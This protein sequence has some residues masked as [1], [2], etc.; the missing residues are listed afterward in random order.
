[1]SCEPE[2]GAL[3]HL[4]Q[5]FAAHIRDPLHY[6]APAGI[7]DRRMNIYRGLLYRNIEGFIASGFPVLRAILPESRW[8]AM[9]RGFMADYRCQTPYFLEIAQE[10][11]NYLQ[12]SQ[13][14][15]PDPPF[16]I[17]LAHYEW[18]ELALDISD[19]EPDWSS[20][21]VNG[22]LLEGVP[23]ISPTAWS[24]A[25]HYPVHEIG[26]GW[27]QSGWEQSGWEQSG[28]EQNQPGSA[29]PDVF[30]IVYRNRE[31]VVRFMEINAVTSRLVELASNNETASGGELIAQLALE[32]GRACDAALMLAGAEILSKLHA[33]GIALGVR[34]GA[35][36]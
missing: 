28:W 10:F 11:I 17:E 27:E 32:M 2:R 3:A 20:I 9:V 15:H 25:Y 19:A 5:V 8:H 33:S 30:L 22:D 34:A 29:V 1:M 6:P 18:V 23:V 24:L 31:D 16:L 13:P 12:Q 4:Q 7:E 26:P 21:D 36:A 35:S 14:E